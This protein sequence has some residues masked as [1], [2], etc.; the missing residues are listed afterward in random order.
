MSNCNFKGEQREQGRKKGL[1][2]D[3]RYKIS[4][5]RSSSNAKQNK[6]TENHT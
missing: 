3:K 2:Y 1:K 6:Y 5:S 4:D